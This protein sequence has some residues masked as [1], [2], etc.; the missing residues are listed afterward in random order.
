M[1][2]VTASIALLVALSACATG[3]TTS[4]TSTNGSVPNGSIGVFGSELI[5]MDNCD[6][7]LTYYQEQALELVGPYGLNNGRYELFTDVAVEEMAVDAAAADGR[8]SLPL[9]RTPAPTSR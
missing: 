6:E 8:D 2:L 3:D 1:R 9:P 5:A 7:L 4:T